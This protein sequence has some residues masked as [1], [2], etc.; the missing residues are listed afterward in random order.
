MKA[1]IPAGIG[2]LGLAGGLLVANSGRSASA[3]NSQPAPVVMNSNATGVD[4]PTLVNCGEGR[5]AVFFPAQSGL[6]R[7]EC[8][9]RESTVNPLLPVGYS[10]IQAGA[11]FADLQT[12]APAPA[13]R[14]VVEER[15]VYRDRPV[16]RTT[17]ARRAPARTY[18][19]A[20]SSPTYSSP[21]V[22]RK[23][24]RSWKKSAIIIGGSTAAGAGV[25]AVL[26]GKSGAKKGA[27]V[28]LVG[29]TVYDIATRNKK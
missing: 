25:G 21:E 29:G 1:L 27:V 7:V 23:E 28:G 2:V 26:D 14:T 22:Y 3:Q 6:S 18:R 19:T 11:Q 16:A 20:S 5:Q 9:A 4:G 17:T 13:T 12:S 8:V 15:V 10:G 24:P